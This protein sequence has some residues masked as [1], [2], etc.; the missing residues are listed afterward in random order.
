VVSQS[1]IDQA[2]VELKTLKRFRQ[3]LNDKLL[4]LNVN[5]LITLSE[6]TVVTLKDEGLI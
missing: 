2:K 1:D 6:D 3:E 4:Q 5:T